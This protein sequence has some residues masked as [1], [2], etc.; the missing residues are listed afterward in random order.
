MKKFA[1]LLSVAPLAAAHPAAAQTASQNAETTT[2]AAAPAPARPAFTTGVAKGRDPLDSAISISTLSEAQVERLSARSL[3]EIYRNIPGVRAEAGN[4]EV[5][6]NYSIRGLPLASNGS[7]FLQFQEDGLPVLEFGDMVNL[8]P[9]LFMRPD[10]NLSQI[11]AIRGG[12][13]STFASNSPGGIIAMMSKTGE[14]AGG[15]VQTTVGLGYDH[16]RVDMDY[17]APLSETLR[18]H[19]GGFYRAGEGPRETGYT[20][21]RGGQV[22]ANVTK[23]FT[24][25]YIRFYGKYV[26]D[27]VPDYSD[28]PLR[29]T[30]TNDDP[31]YEPLAGFDPRRD[32]LLSPYVSE[33]LTLDENNNRLRDDARDGAH[34]VYASF[35]TEVKFEI[36][37][38][39]VTN[40]FRYANVSGGSVRYLPLQV[41]PAALLAQAF[42]GPGAQ[43]SYATGPNAG[44]VITNPSTING[45]GLLSAGF[46]M[47][48]HVNGLDNFTNLSLIHI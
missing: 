34:S 10:F 41:G 25:G 11:Q 28:V 46:M 48:F 18:F 20:A 14:T 30:G 3:T 37:E 27:R 35:G 44:Q 7:K 40:K 21:Y 45:N 39:T 43:L 36:D 47:S 5:S 33:V 15:A 4:G 19:I 6:G 42:G 29:V 32:T 12:S 38:W 22:K 9:D 24:G 1:L 23:D 31:N 2:D 8:G 17:G 13:A 16:Y 26:D